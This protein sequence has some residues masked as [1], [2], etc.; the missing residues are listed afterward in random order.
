MT[1]PS[2]TTLASLLQAAKSKWKQPDRRL[3]D[4]GELDLVRR[5]W[6]DMRKRLEAV[7][8][9][10]REVARLMEGLAE[11]VPAGRDIVFWAGD[12][13][14]NV[15]LGMLATVLGVEDEALAAELFKDLSP[16]TLRLLRNA[17]P[18]CCP[19]CGKRK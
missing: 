7:D 19:L 10:L 16:A 18:F 4:C 5:M 11:D 17:E 3:V 8:N 1:T 13:T 2:R 15:P 9:A 12:P 6:I 14:A